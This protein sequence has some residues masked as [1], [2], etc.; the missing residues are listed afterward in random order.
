[1][2]PLTIAVTG[3]SGF[4]GSHLVGRLTQAG[5]RVRALRRRS[6]AP[7]TPAAL[8]WIDGDL[9]SGRGI[10]E[11]LA[12]ADAVV[13]CAGAVRG[14]RPEDFDINVSGTRRVAEAARA[15]RV[16]RLLVL[17]SLAARQPEL[18][19]YAASKRAGEEV[20]EGLDVCWTVFRPP[21]VYGPGDVELAPLFGLMLRGIAVTP[22]HRG[23][24]SLLFVADLV[25]AIVAWL[26]APA[27]AGKCLE[28]DDG[29]PD[30]YDWQRIIAVAAAIRGK[31]VLHLAVPR[32]WLALPAHANQWLGRHLHYAPMLTPGKL[33]ELYHTDWVCRTDAVE[34]LLNWRPSVPFA[35]GLA[36]TFGRR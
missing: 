8:T 18:S 21:A 14:A 17:S 30:G 15:H 3:A 12:G 23:R 6:T 31:R 11:L 27:I 35:D 7:A 34:T 20:L 5:Y 28:L 1:V 13:H 26:D 32:A 33:N 4:I 19:M 24:F 22:A 10:D 29:T 25:D 2:S 9:A 36:L 16:D